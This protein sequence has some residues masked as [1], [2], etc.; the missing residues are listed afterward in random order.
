MVMVIGNT[1]HDGLQLII[2]PNLQSSYG[3][4]HNSMFV[5]VADRRYVS[6]D[7]IRSDQTAELSHLFGLLKALDI[8]ENR[9]LVEILIDRPRKNTDDL[10]FQRPVFSGVTL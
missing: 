6:P 9:D 8:S 2:L 7:R 4:I 1:R 3:F 10:I 5:G